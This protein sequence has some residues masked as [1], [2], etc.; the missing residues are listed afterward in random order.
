MLRS[1]TIVAAFW[2]A[3]NA[4]AADLDGAELTAKVTALDTQLF[5]AYNTCDLPALEALVEEVFDTQTL[6]GVAIPFAIEVRQHHAR[7]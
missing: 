3:S 6:G 4:T 1:I 7:R 5:N 2:L